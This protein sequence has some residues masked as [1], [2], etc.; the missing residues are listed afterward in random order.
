MFSKG[1]RELIEYQ[2]VKMFNPDLP[3]LCADAKSH[4]SALSA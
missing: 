1:V 4:N 3:E 2:E